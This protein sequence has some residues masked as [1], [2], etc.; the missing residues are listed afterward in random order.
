MALLTLVRAPGYT[1]RG[2]RRAFLGQNTGPNLFQ[3]KSFGYY[4]VV[5]LVV[6]WHSLPPHLS[7]SLWP[8]GLQH[9]RL[10]RLSLSPW[11]CLNSCEL[12]TITPRK[13]ATPTSE[14]EECFVNCYE[15]ILKTKILWLFLQ[16]CITA[17]DQT[18]RDVWFEAAQPHLPEKVMAPH[19]STLAWKIPWM[20]EPGGLQSMGLGRV[21]HDWSDLAVAADLEEKLWST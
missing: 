20:E 12:I 11:V 5:Q 17:A 13:S 1:A 10:P 7:D 16:V 9:A 2:S 4:V 14:P 6:Q 15:D 21:G 8:C 18:G 3:G 19:S